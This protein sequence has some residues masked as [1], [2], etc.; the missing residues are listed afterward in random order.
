MAAATDGRKAGLEAAPSPSPGSPGYVPS[1]A[2]L[3]AGFQAWLKAAGYDA[4]GKPTLTWETPDGRGGSLPLLFVASAVS[5]LAGE[6]RELADG[7]IAVL[8]EA[9]VGVAVRGSQIAAEIDEDCDHTAGTFRR[10]TKALRDDGLIASG[11]EGYCLC[12]RP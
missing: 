3:A 12:S 11:S 6:C 7:I 9:G 8:T 1:L 4:V 5:Q 10:A 2:E